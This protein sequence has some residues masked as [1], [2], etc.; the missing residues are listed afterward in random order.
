[1]HQAVVIGGLVLLAGALPSVALSGP[2]ARPISEI[3]DEWRPAVERAWTAFQQVQER[4]QGRLLEELGSKGPAGAVRIC[5]EEAPALTQAVSVESGIVLG[6]TSHRLRNPANQPRTWAQTYV[7]ANAGRAA[8]EVEP[9][10][11]DLGTRI[12]VLRSI[13]TVGPCL[14]CHGNREAMDPQLR[15]VLAELYPTDQAVGFREG[16][17]RG[18]FWAEVD[19]P[20]V[21]EPPRNGERRKSNPTSGE[22]R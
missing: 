19:K 22:G 3:P 12:G 10:W 21:P 9:V 14:L 16:D 1:M 18:F 4:L 8:S 6:R 20:V 5:R 11:F 17:L 13:P 2:P 7:T 15:A